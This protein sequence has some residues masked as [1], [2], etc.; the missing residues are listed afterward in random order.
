[1]GGSPKSR[2][3]TRPVRPRDLSAL[4]FPTVRARLA[5]LAASSAGQERCR[6]IVPATD[7]T[8]AD[9]ALERA[10]ECFRLLEQHGDPTLRAFPDVRS[11]L[12]SAAHEGFTLDGKTLVAVRQTLESIRV[13]GAFFRRHGAG[14]GTLG[15][16]VG[17]LIPFPHLENALQRALDE[18][19]TVLDQASDA[20][21]RVRASIRRLPRAGT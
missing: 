3:Y 11:H 14:S 7:R 20:L 21:A 10:W 6:A 19:G 9:A 8:A 13:V 5:E 15:D 16:L 1:M 18:D 17:R 12:R 2:R 4:E